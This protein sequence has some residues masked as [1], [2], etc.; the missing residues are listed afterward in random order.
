MKNVVRG[1]GAGLAAL[2]AASCGGAKN[3]AVTDVVAAPEGEEKASLL[4]LAGRDAAA[5]SFSDLA[6]KLAEKGWRVRVVE[7]GEKEWTR[8]LKQA[9][10]PER[11]TVAGGF[12]EAG[13]FA[14]DYGADHDEDGVDGVILLGGLLTEGRNY[15]LE[16]FRA[17]VI[18]A[19]H[20]GLVTSAQAQAQSRDYPPRSTFLNIRGGNRAGFVPGRSFE[21]DSEAT[22]PVEEQQ[23]VTMELINSLMVDFCDWR[24]K[25][26]DKRAEDAAAA[27]E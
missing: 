20:D 11:C 4:F 7:G 6:A 9:F 8:A 22:M 24:I 26:E 17:G 5:A 1:L 25:R 2:V 15:M 27:K 13:T 3:A 21:T 14:M 23:R 12:A 19:E 10:D 18:T 16:P